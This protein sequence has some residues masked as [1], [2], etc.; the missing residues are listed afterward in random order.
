MRLF[1]LL[2]ALPLV[3]ALVVNSGCGGDKA[4]PVQ[5]ALTAYKPVIEPNLQEGETLS[6][7]FVAITLDKVETEEAIRRMKEEA[8]PLAEK[9]LEQAQAIQISE[10]MVQGLHQKLVDASTLRVEGYKLMVQGYNEKNLEI[11]QQ[12]RQKITDSKILEETYFGDL[13]RLALENGL[14]IQFFVPASA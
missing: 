13:N 1:P 11:F 2:A 5:T 10:P 3:F 4:S 7:L 14:Q 12:G 8:I 9:L 6:K